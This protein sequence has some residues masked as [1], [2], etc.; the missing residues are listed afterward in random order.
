MPD[1]KEWCST[2]HSEKADEMEMMSSQRMAR[3]LLVVVASAL[4]FSGLY[5]FV[6]IL[7]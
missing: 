5:Y 2:A 7:E 4:V 6:Q 3:W 1:E